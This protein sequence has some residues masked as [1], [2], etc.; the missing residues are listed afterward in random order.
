MKKQNKIKGSTK[1]ER[2]EK[3]GI[4]WDGG[5]VDRTLELTKRLLGQKPFKA[6]RRDLCQ[7]ILFWHHEYEQKWNELGSMR[8]HIAATVKGQELFKMGLSELRTWLD[9]QTPH[10]TA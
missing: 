6:S 3:F 10:S 9:R 5:S 2:K 4:P 7:A 1:R 8:C